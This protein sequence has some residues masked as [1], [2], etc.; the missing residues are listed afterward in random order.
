M[1]SLDD[2]EHYY[3]DHFPDERRKR[4]RRRAFDDEPVRRGRLTEEEKDRLAALREEPEPLGLP[5]D[6]DR[7]STWDTGERGPEPHP[8]WVVT[9]LA[10]VDHEL[11]VLK[12]GK[13][14]DVHLLRRSLPGGESCLLAAKRYRDGDHRLFHRD[15]G[16]LEG[17]RMRRSREMRAIEHRTAFGRGMIAQQWAVAEFRMLGALWR[18]GAPV[19]YPVQRVGGEVLQEF[20]G[21]ADGTAAPRL[22]ALRPDRAELAQLW[23]QL[24]DALA[25]LAGQ[26]YAHGDLSAYNVLVHRDRL[27][28]IDLPQAVDLAANPQ[29]LDYL[30]RDADNITAWFH[31]AGFAGADATE[32]AALLAEEA[33]L[34]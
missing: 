12:T 28:L 17:R 22:A 10:A 26:G 7:W 34:G 11:G 18:A 21:E 25:V 5:E 23:E 31:R 8:D 27:V 4:P 13:E 24:V 3:D 1:P 33:N 32:L 29:G 9:A 14:A 2:Y 6:A 16:Y 20:I 30:A 19:P 15:A